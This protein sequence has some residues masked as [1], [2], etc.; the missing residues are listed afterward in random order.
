MTT[1]EHREF[2]H[3]LA[4]VV[5]D[6]IGLSDKQSMEAVE[7][8]LDTVDMR[9][10]RQVLCVLGGLGKLEMSV[11][12]RLLLHGLTDRVVDRVMAVE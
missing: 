12:E 2:E 6:W 1:R 3:H 4:F 7:V 9:A 8:I 5:E 10:I 11:T